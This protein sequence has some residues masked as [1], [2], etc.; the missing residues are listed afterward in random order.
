MLPSCNL[1]FPNHCISATPRAHG[2]LKRKLRNAGE[3]LQ[4]CV[5][6]LISQSQKGDLLLLIYKVRLFAEVGVSFC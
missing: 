2:D 3:A 5:H 1:A 6:L 4:F